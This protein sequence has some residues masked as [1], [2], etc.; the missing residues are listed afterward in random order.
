M[1]QT[2]HGAWYDALDPRQKAMVDHAVSYAYNY[3][4]AGVPGHGAHLLIAK[5]ADELDKVAM[6]PT[7]RPVVYDQENQCYRDIK[8]GVKVLP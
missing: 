5:L 1:D 7:V 4:H 8:T 6:R 3:S 2:K